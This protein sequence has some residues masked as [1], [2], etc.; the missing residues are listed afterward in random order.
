MDSPTGDHP[1]FVETTRLCCQDR[2]IT[3]QTEKSRPKSSKGICGGR[4]YLASNLTSLAFDE[5]YHVIVRCFVS[6]H[7]SVVTRDL[8]CIILLYDEMERAGPLSGLTTSCSCRLWYYFLAVWR[9]S[10]MTL[11]GCSNIGGFHDTLEAR[12]LYCLAG[13]RPQIRVA[14]PHINM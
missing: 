12:L 8:P 7:T 2:L 9:W 4:S 6:V 1:W 3:A 10:T 11:H 13:K 14:E 5:W